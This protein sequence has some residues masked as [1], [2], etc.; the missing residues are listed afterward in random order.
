[1]VKVVTNNSEAYTYDNPNNY[2]HNDN[3]TAPGQN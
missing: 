3:Y 1:M 2:Y